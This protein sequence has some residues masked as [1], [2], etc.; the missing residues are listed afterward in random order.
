M[1][2]IVN[3]DWNMENLEEKV[4]IVVVSFLKEVFGVR[5]GGDNEPMGG[6]HGAPPPEFIVQLEI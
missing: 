5:E 4:E 6:E 1:S 2:K 3:L